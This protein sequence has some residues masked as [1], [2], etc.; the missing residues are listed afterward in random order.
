[1]VQDTQN[2]V[3]RRKFLKGGTLAAGAAAGGLAMPA[4]VTAQAP[5]TL[6]MQ[7]SWTASDIFHE[8]AQQLVDR[9]QAMSGGRLQID[10][11]PAGAIV[12]AFQ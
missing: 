7:S 9:I 6:R 2:N 1:M 3:S 12:G 10:L 11:T 8:M 5:L 4:V